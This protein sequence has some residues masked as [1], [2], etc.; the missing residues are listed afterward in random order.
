MRWGTW[1]ALFYTAVAALEMDE[2]VAVL[3]LAKQ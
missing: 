2:V 3:V 1:K